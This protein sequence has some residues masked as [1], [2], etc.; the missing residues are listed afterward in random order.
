MYLF[1][2]DPFGLSNIDISVACFNDMIII[3]QKKKGCGIDKIVN[4]WAK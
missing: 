3:T 4:Q 2:Y 1:F